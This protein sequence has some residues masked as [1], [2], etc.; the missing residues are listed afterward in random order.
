MGEEKYIQIKMFNKYHDNNENPYSK[1]SKSYY[2]DKIDDEIKKKD[3]EFDYYKIP[4]KYL[5]L[6]PIE[7]FGN[8]NETKYMFL[9]CEYED[10]NEFIEKYLKRG[11]KKVSN[12]NLE[13]NIFRRYNEIKELQFKMR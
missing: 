3:K 9:K 6:P 10:Y 4:I 1:Y 13:M 5:E 7:K 12:Y 11:D 2:V 8:Y